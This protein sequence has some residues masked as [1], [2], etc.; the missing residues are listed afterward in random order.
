MI[1]ACPAGGDPGY[2]EEILHLAWEQLLVSSLRSWWK[3]LGRGFLWASLLW[4]LHPRTS[5]CRW[6]HLRLMKGKAFSDAS[7]LS[8]GVGGTNVWQ[9][10]LDFHCPAKLM[11]IYQKYI[12]VFWITCWIS[13]N[14]PKSQQESNLSPPEVL[15]T[16]QKF[17]RV[18]LTA[19]LISP[20][21]NY[22]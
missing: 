15:K 12:L 1:Q 14:V 19:G 11:L 6:D 21:I 17:T 3:R 13:S 22:P 7:S 2:T 5:T 8:Y 16:C 20:G 18:P 9:A 4:L 10:I